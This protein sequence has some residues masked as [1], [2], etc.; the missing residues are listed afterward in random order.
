MGNSAWLFMGT[1]LLG[2]IPGS[3]VPLTSSLE[4]QMLIPYSLFLGNEELAM[5]SQDSF[6]PSFSTC[7]DDVMEWKKN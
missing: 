5:I 1:E 4:P 3:D 7:Q 6:G 2:G